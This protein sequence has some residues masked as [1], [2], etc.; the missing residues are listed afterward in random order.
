[1]ITIQLPF[2]SGYPQHRKNVGNKGFFMRKKRWYVRVFW[3]I[4]RAK[5]LAPEGVL[6]I[7]F[8]TNFFIYP[9]HV[10]K[11][12]KS[13]CTRLI[14]KY[15]HDFGNTGN[16]S[17]SAYNGKVGKPHDQTPIISIMRAAFSST[18]MASTSAGVK[19]AVPVRTAHMH[20]LQ[21]A[22]K[23]AVLLSHRSQ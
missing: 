17:L 19:V 16:T 12:T 2:I 13:P 14:R 20:S 8:S 15:A 6:S 23:T 10:V 5:Y 18:H 22:A 1:M 21:S 4:H 9:F 7:D 11:I 3:V